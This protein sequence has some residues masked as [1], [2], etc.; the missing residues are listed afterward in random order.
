MSEFIGAIIASLFLARFSNDFF[1]GCLYAIIAGIMVHISI[2]ELLPAS[3]KYNKP[4]C[5]VLF[6]IV[7]LLFMFVSSLLLH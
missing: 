5:T 3:F 2:Y 1:M 6:F 4:L 7:G